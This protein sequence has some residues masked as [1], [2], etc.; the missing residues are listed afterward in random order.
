METVE[1]AAGRK[2]DLFGDPE[3]P[4]VLMWHGSQ[5]DARATMGPLARR[6]ADQGFAVVV[7]DWN[8]HA[9]DRGREDLVQSLQFVGERS[10][11]AGM[12]L[13]GWSMGGV[14]AAGATI[15]AAQLGIRIARTVC[16]AGA[17]V[18]SDPI[19]GRPL[20]SD[21]SDHHD[22][23]PFTL[24]HGDADVVIPVGVSRQWSATLRR[25]SWPVDLIELHADHG[26]IAGAAYQ[27]E[28][29]RYVPSEEPAILS[30]ASDVAARIVAAAA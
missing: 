8:S 27:P 11:G 30:V 21:L 10:L 22:R 17:F 29:D 14:A 7:P 25:H 23:P 19:S 2:A 9:D 13:V 5:A 3:H 6:V 18:V 15:H 28:Q 1:Y 16:L 24:L 12:V 26:S 4:S 20:P